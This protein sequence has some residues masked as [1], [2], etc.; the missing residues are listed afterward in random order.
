MFTSQEGWIRK[1]QMKMTVC[2]CVEMQESRGMK[3]CSEVADGGGEGAGHDVH[4]N[5]AERRNKGS[6]LFILKLEQLGS[7]FSLEEPH[8]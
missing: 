1:I 7:F 4:E 3:G 8:E 5:S 2:V 6:R